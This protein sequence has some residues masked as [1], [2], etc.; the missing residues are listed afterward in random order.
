[1]DLSVSAGEFHESVELRALRLVGDP[2]PRGHPFAGAERAQIV[3][4]VPH[5]DPDIGVPVRLRR[6]RIPM[7][8]RDL[9]DPLD[10]DRIVDM[11]ELVDAFGRRD[12]VERERLHASSTVVTI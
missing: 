5:D 2:G 6:R 12:E 8:G 11:A 9:L 10:P 4:L 7:A 3:D 1:M